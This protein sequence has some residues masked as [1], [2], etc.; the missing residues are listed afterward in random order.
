MEWWYIQD[1]ITNLGVT[2]ANP[3]H[4][5][6]DINDLNLVG[7]EYFATHDLILVSEDENLVHICC[8][9]LEV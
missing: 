9:Q 1:L 7:G 3:F 6:E 2:E 4:I 8:K 5:S